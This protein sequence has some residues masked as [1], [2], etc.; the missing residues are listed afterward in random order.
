[1]SLRA[2]RIV[3]GAAISFE[4]FIIRSLHPFDRLRAGYGRDDKEREKYENTTNRG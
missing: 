3:E 4:Q 2:I 1:M